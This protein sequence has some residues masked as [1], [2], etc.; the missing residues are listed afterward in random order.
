MNMMT[1]REFE[2]NRSSVLSGTVVIIDDDELGNLTS[3]ELHEIVISTAIQEDNW[4]SYDDYDDD[5]TYEV[6]EN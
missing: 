3:D 1:E 4:Q 2:V 5:I 6:T